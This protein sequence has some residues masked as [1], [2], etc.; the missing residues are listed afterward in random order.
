V[1][2]ERNCTKT[3]TTRGTNVAAVAVKPKWT[4]EW[5]WS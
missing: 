5:A 1:I 3:Y 4:Q 2:A